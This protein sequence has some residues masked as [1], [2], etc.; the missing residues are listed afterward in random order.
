MQQIAPPSVRLARPHSSQGS[1]LA[2][3]TGAND[4]VSACRREG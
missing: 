1:I 3:L 4:T 2:V